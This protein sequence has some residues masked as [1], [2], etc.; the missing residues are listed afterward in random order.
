MEQYS[1]YLMPY[2]FIPTR[3]HPRQSKFETPTEEPNNTTTEDFIIE[4]IH[5]E[6][7]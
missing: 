6:M 7:S 2:V 1:Q 5:F 3:Q 4:D